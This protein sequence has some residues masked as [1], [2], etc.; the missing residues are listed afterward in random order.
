M[1][2]K[3]EIDAQDAKRLFSRLLAE[4]LLPGQGLE[5]T[6]MSW[7]EYSGVEMT[8]ETASVPPLP[9]PNPIE[10]DIPY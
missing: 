1:K 8:L 7:R 6:E 2:M 4:K 5:V 9:P 3:I 10:D